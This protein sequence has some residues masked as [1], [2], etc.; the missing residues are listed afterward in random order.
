MVHEP[1]PWVLVALDPGTWYPGSWIRDH[2]PW[3]ILRSSE[4]ESFLTQSTTGKSFQNTQERERC[5]PILLA[6]S[7]LNVQVVTAPTIHQL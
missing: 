6:L 7:R 2:A 1:I 5:N 4:Q 3:Y